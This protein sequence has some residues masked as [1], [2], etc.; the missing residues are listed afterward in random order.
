MT[1]S[2]DGQF[3][4][5]LYA[6]SQCPGMDGNDLACSDPAV[7]PAS[8]SVPMTKG[9]TIYVIVDGRGGQPEEGQ[10]TLTLDLQ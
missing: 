8:I 7:V 2:V 6:R 4:T 1:A 5:L 10:F 3:T 9:Q